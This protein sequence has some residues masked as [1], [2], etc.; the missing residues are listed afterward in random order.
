[1]RKPTLSKSRSQSNFDTLHPQL[2][3]GF[4][5]LVEDL[6]GSPDELLKDNGLAVQSEGKS[7]KKAGSKIGYKALANLLEQAAQRLDTQDF[8]LRLARKQS[9]T[10]SFGL[11]ADLMCSSPTFGDGMDYVVE[12]NYIHS[13]AAKIWKEPY[14]SGKLVFIGH[15]VLIEGVPNKQQLMEFVLLLGHLGAQEFTAGYARARRVHFRHRPV[16]EKSKYRRY[17]GCGVYFDQPS[18]GI[19]FSSKDMACEVVNP[20]NAIFENVVAYL[21]SHISERA[22]PLHAQTRGIITHLLGA[23]QSDL[24]TVAGKLNLHPRK[25]HRCLKEEGTTFQKIKDEVRRDAMVYYLQNTHLSLTAISEKLDFAEQAI[26]TRSCQR[27]LSKSPTQVRKD[28][29]L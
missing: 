29:F 8:G 5:Q 3:Q 1:M 23:G 10:N 22:A 16:S 17:F 11:V 28:F 6:G 27:W 7:G 9:I 26:M 12:H 25:L 20:D 19:C 18:D 14:E 13:L 15:D 4:A 24:E 2:L 21:E